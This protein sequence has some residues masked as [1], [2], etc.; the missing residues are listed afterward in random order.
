MNC[1]PTPPW[2]PIQIKATQKRK[3]RITRPWAGVNERN[4]LLTQSGATQNE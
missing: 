1:H 3:S 2:E 4:L